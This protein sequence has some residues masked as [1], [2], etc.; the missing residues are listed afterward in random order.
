[1]VVVAVEELAGAVPAGAALLVIEGARAGV[2]EE[3]E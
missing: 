2:I 3:P 1:V